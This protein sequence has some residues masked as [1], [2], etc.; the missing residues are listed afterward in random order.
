MPPPKVSVCIDVYNY[1]DF[2]PKAIESALAQTLRDLEVIVVDDC[3]TDDSYAV[4]CRYAK[5]DDRVRVH[6]NPVNLG[7]VK[8][9]NACLK[10]AQGEF[11][12]FVHADDY[13]CAPDALA[14]MVARMEANPATS[15][16]A[17]AMQHVRADGSPQGMFTAALFGTPF[18]GGNDNH[19]ALP[20]GA[21]KPHWRA[22]RDALPPQPGRAGF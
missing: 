9:R 19:F 7:M 15:L 2:L 16:V 22:E 8:N 10:L 6:R 17:C 12:K 13:L 14:K 5:Q 20:A 1:A 18:L 4:A 11:V 21:E 3:S